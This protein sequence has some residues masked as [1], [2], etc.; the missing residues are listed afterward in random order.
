MNSVAYTG[1]Y[2][3]IGR[4]KQITQAERATYDN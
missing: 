4:F 2:S 3:S 1:G